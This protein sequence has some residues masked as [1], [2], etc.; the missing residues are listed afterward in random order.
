MP[1][2]IGHV[3][4]KDDMSEEGFKALYLLILFELRGYV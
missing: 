2:G 4:A 1:I 3:G